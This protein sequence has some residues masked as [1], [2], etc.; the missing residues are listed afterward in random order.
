VEDGRLARQQRKAR[1][2]VGSALHN[3]LVLLTKYRV[4]AG[5]VSSKRRIGILTVG[6]KLS[7]RRIFEDVRNTGENRLPYLLR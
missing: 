5:V 6:G 2:S 4:S 3:Y 7:M 1:S